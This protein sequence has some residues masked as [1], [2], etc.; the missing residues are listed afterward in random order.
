MAI[1]RLLGLGSEQLTGLAIG[2]NQPGYTN[3]G[4][5]FVGLW[6]L[7]GS[8]FA[9]LHPERLCIVSTSPVFKISRSGLMIYLGSPTR[10]YILSNQTKRLVEL[11]YVRRG[12]SVICIGHLQVYG[13]PQ[14]KPIYINKTRIPTK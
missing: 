6:G 2:P 10:E 4:F 8:G 14:L 7:E 3:L 1:H 9:C 12:P 11:N 13:L 5:G